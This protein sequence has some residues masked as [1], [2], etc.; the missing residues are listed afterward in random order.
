M[1]GVVSP[2]RAG[3]GGRRAN[4]NILFYCLQGV[5]V[6]SCSFDNLVVSQLLRV[7]VIDMDRSY[8]EGLNQFITPEKGK[9]TNIRIHYSVVYG[10]HILQLPVLHY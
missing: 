3:L 9:Y 5:T 4:G 10:V 6:E 1:D 8:H 7:Q 2:Q